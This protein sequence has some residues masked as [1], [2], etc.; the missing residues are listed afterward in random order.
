M[1]NVAFCRYLPASTWFSTGVE[2]ARSVLLA[3]NGDAA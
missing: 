3:D 2:D 1:K